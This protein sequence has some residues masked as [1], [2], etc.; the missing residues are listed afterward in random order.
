MHAC[1]KNLSLIPICCGKNVCVWIALRGLRNAEVIKQ[2]SLRHPIVTNVYVY[3]R[4][5]KYIIN[6]FIIFVK[7][8]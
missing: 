5:F 6:I 3:I 1:E 7:Y 4:I 8:S 2:T